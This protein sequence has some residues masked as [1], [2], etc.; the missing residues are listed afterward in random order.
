LQRIAGSR[1]SE[2]ERIL[3]RG[4]NNLRAARRVIRLENRRAGGLQKQHLASRTASG[5]SARISFPSEVP[6]RLSS[7]SLILAVVAFH[8]MLTSAFAQ[9]EPSLDARLAARRDLELAKL[10]LRQYWQ[11]DY[12]RQQREL[13]AA[14]EMTELEIRN[15]Q[16]RLRAYQPFTRFSTGQPFLITIQDLQMCLRAAELRL[17]NLREERNN[18]IRFHSDNWRLLEMKVF[19]ARLRVATL[20][21][22]D[23]STAGPANQQP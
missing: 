10:E 20:E 19:D 9:N 23:E 14:I 7:A 1:I 3:V 18:L 8:S 2:R 6:M 21:A 22:H 16:E 12:P 11:V 4:G 17:D 5:S 15:Y 13:N